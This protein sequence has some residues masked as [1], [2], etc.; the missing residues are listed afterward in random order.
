MTSEELAGAIIRAFVEGG[1]AFL[2]GTLA[3]ALPAV[4]LLVLALHFARP[5]VLDTTRGLSLRLAADIWWILY[6]AIRDGLIA[7]AFVMSF[8]Y[9]FPDVLVSEELP[10]GGSLAT[11]ALFAVLLTKLVADADD[12]PRAFAVV[13]WLLTAGALLYV[14]PTLVGVQASALGLGDPWDRLAAALVTSKNP[15]LAIALWWIS[16]AAISAM[17]LAAVWFNLRAP[18]DVPREAGS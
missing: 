10:I 17:G 8:M 16:V 14:G 4:W 6:L 3:A 7:L 9:L 15:A 11:A 1:E 13:S 18:A 5:Y 12:D 2:E